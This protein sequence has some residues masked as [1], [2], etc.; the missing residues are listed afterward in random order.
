MTITTEY[1][2]GLGHGDRLFAEV[3]EST[4]GRL[5]TL[6]DAPGDEGR[7]VFNLHVGDPAYARLLAGAINDA[8]ELAPFASTPRQ[9]ATMDDETRRRT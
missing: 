7:E 6:K 1:I 2:I 8:A 4:G 5:V 3:R 9:S